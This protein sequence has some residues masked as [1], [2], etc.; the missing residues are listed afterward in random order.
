MSP[1]WRLHFAPLG[2]K[3]QSRPWSKP[4]RQRARCRSASSRFGREAVVPLAQPTS[5]ANANGNLEVQS[6]A[7]GEPFATPDSK[8]VWAE[9]W[10]LDGVPLPRTK[11]RRRS[12]PEEAGRGLCFVGRD[13]ARRARPGRN[14]DLQSLGQSFVESHKHIICKSDRSLI[15]CSSPGCTYTAIP[16]LRRSRRFAPSKRCMV[17]VACRVPSAAPLCSGPAA[18]TTR[19]AGLAGMPAYR[20]IIT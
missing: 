14:R 18:P 15:I 5:L 12:G 16:S 8:T 20:N 11:P 17:A 3:L 1:A 9:A 6:I 10:R 7:R 2:A 19:P 4:G 13:P